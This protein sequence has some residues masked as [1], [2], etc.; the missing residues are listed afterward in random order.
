MF[1]KRPHI[2]FD[3]TI[4]LGHA[5]SVII[6]ILGGIFAYTDLKQDVRVEHATNTAK[7]VEYDRLWV[8]QQQK[9]IE[10]NDK[11]VRIFQNLTEAMR[12]MKND[13]RADIR[14][15]HEAVRK[16]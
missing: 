13:I 8:L 12:D 5:G 10:Q 15:L 14:D 11:M 6:F 4:S 2:K 7:F 3:W 9:D 1:D 16:R